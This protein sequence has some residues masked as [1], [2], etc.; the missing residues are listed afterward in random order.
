MAM[1]DHKLVK[2][3]DYEEELT[4]QD[5]ELLIQRKLHRNMAHS[6][7]RGQKSS[8]E[9]S[10]SFCAIDA[11]DRVYCVPIAILARTYPLGLR[12]RA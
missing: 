11:P 12:E 3:S 1:C 5:L 10:K 9:S 6:N 7:E 2:D 4:I 8:I